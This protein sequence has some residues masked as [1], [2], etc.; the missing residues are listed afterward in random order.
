MLGRA[1][2]SKN[3]ALVPALDK[4]SPRFF[5]EFFYH[6]VDA[7]AVRKSRSGRPSKESNLTRM[8]NFFLKNI[9]SSF[10]RDF[11]RRSKKLVCFDS[12]GARMKVARI[13]FP[14]LDFGISGGIWWRLTHRTIIP[15]ALQCP[16]RRL[17]RGH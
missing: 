15:V 13:R 7:V 3:E 4:M 6:V 9:S 10:I 14:V 16:T 1:Q 12:I 2:S 8:Q 17:Y 11:R 5:C